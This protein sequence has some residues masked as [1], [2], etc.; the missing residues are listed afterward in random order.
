MSELLMPKLG[1][2]MTDGIIAEW[3]VQPGDSFGQGDA[4]FLV[5]TDKVISEVPAEVPGVMVEHLAQEQDVVEVGKVVAILDV[6]SE[7]GAGNASSGKSS[8][9]DL[10]PPSDEDTGSTSSKLD[11][12][13][14]PKQET[15]ENPARALESGLSPR[16]IATP[17]ARRIAIKSGVDLSV[18]QGSGPRGRIKAADVELFVSTQKECESDRKSLP[19]VDEIGNERITPTRTQ[20]AIAR[21]LTQNK[22]ITPHFYLSSH[23]E[24]TALNKLRKS[25]NDC[26][27]F[28]KVTINHLLVA[29]VGRVIQ[30]MP[31][32]NRIWVDDEIVQLSS[33]DVGVAVNTEYGL[34]VPVV[35]GVGAH[36]FQHIVL[37]A[38]EA[39]SK[40]RNG[41]LSPD[42]MSGGAISI[43]NAG[44]FQVDMMYPIINP[45]HSM[46]LGIGS[47]Q[48][49]FRP[50]ESGHP[51]L[52]NEMGIGFSG[53]HRIL[54]GH[55]GLRFLNAFI[56]I[57][58]NPLMIIV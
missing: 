38:Q 5:E 29:A 27:G 34:Y 3:L 50:D 36:S 23:A 44:M 25:L 33:V 32:F 57:I 24:V 46:I 9:R 31:E 41:N 39:I 28:P 43:S 20:I 35:K 6:G 52:R 7:R 42:D 17:L 30:R 49:N 14:A 1:L 12:K 18:V 19:K 58:E 55:A 13:L 51:T 15:V 37:D 54:D 21:R 48:P 8:G 26:D 53:D 10:A 40:A 4:L 11:G 22:Q 2:T 56:E 45:G 16:V 47:I